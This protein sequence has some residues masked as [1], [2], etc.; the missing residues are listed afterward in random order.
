MLPK[1]GAAGLAQPGD[2]AAVPC[3]VLVSLASNTPILGKG[4]GCFPCMLSIPLQKKKKKKHY[5]PRKT[6]TGAMLRREN[7]PRPSME[8]QA[9][10]GT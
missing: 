7:Q 6:L 10:A 4:R 9:G 5:L 2:R 1:A 8:A 3:L